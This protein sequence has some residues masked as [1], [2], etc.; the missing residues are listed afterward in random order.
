MGVP[1]QNTQ[2][3]RTNTVKVVHTL[4]VAPRQNMNAILCNTQ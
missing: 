2:E 3:P 4:L 1:K